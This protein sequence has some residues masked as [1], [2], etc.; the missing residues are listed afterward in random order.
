MRALVKLCCDGRQDDGFHF[1]SGVNNT[2]LDLESVKHKE[3]FK[4]LIQYLDKVPKLFDEDCFNTNIISNCLYKI[5]EMSF[6]EESLY[7]RIVDFYNW[8]RR[9]GLYLRIKVKE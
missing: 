9:C 2:I 8:H 1:C 5:Y 7:K 3:N 6:I 4:E